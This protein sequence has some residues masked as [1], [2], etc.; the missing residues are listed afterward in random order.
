MTYS[1]KP[2]NTKDKSVFLFRILMLLVVLGCSLL[3]FLALHPNAQRK[4]LPV[5]LT[6]SCLFTFLMI[7]SISG[8]VVKE[9]IIETE[10]AVL[11]INYFTLFSKNKILEMHLSE[12]AYS[13]KWQ[14]SKYPPKKYRFKI[15]Q[16]NICT[17]Y[18]DSTDDGFSETQFNEL[19]EKFDTLK[20]KRR[21]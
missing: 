4:L 2:Q 8:K 9:F 19:I 12:I 7:Y 16:N 15:Y 20:I 6:V 1:T 10:K 13:Y 17:F 14:P 3:L 21:N 18:M 5:Y 11:K